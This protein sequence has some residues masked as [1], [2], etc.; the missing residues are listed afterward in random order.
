MICGKTLHA[1]VFDQACERSL[2]GPVPTRSFGL[3]V[4]FPPGRECLGRGAMNMTG[5]ANLPVY[6]ARPVVANQAQR[7]PATPRQRQAARKVPF[8]I[9]ILPLV[10]PV[11]RP[12]FRH[13]IEIPLFVPSRF[14]QPTGTGI[15]HPLR[16]RAMSVEHVVRQQQVS[17]RSDHGL[18][19]RPAGLPARPEN[20]AS[21]RLCSDRDDPASSTP[22]TAPLVHGPISTFPNS[23][24]ISAS[25]SQPVTLTVGAV[26]TGRNRSTRYHCAQQQIV[27]LRACAETMERPRFWYLRCGWRV[28]R[29]QTSPFHICQIAFEA[30]SPTPILC[31][32]GQN[33]GRSIV[34]VQALRDRPETVASVDRFSAG[35]F[36]GPVRHPF[37][38]VG[39]E[40]GSGVSSGAKAIPR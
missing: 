27:S 15:P 40:Q 25:L 1:T 36:R 30:V 12:V 23:G 29:D 28:H 11:D 18:R 16:S 26:P 22:G 6:V 39:S 35:L 4:N 32:S 34:S 38:L 2:H 5:V 7:L 9:Q 31:T 3:A 17:H 33:R 10:D 13:G 24:L 21:T 8:V 37:G 14:F 19:P 20:R